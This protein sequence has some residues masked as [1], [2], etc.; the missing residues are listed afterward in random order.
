MSA[1]T[2]AGRRYSLR[3][4]LTMGRCQELGLWVTMT[5][6]EDDIYK[7]A[8]C[9][10][11]Q[12]KSYTTCCEG[13]CG[14]TTCDECLQEGIC[15]VCR[16][17][18]DDEQDYDCG[19]CAGAGLDEDC[20]CDSVCTNCEHVLVGEW[21][22]LECD[23]MIYDE[24]EKW[25]FVC[26]KYEQLCEKCRALPLRCD[27]CNIDFVD[28]DNDGQGFEPPRGELAYGAGNRWCENC[29][30]TEFHCAPPRE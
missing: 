4:P 24:V 26:G 17:C 23:E 29:W 14:L 2:P 11:K 1:Y 15:D 13:K 10:K 27:R 19:A 12:D 30:Y 25:A 22:C 7:C 28:D 6:D 21:C 8:C 18:A 5:A 20:D 16:H 9:W 3:L